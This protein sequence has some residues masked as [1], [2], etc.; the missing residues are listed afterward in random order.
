[1]RSA[2][3]SRNGLLAVVL[4]VLTSGCFLDEID[5]AANWQERGS[6]KADPAPAASPQPSASTGG[7]QGPNWWA[8]AKSL[9]SEEPKTEIVQ[10]RVGK[11]TQFTGREDCLARGGSVE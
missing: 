2:I 4:A 8:S 9:G 6:E 7:M 10:C 3:R 11:T 1:M 5:K